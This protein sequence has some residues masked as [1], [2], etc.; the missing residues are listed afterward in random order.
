MYLSPNQ[1]RN[2]PRYL[3]TTACVPH[4]PHTPSTGR[5]DSYDLSSTAMGADPTDLLSRVRLFQNPFQRPLNVLKDVPPRTSLSSAL[6]PVWDD[7]E[8]KREQQVRHSSDPAGLI[9][10][11][12]P[13]NTPQLQLHLPPKSAPDAP[14]TASKKSSFA[15]HVIDMKTIKMNPAALIIADTRE[16]VK[17]PSFD[18]MMEDIF[19]QSR[20]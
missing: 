18:T 15:K 9:R 12:T 20:H 1:V 7:R 10:A 5:K 6:R 4:A 13:F 8:G 3:A 2:L 17:D 11:R 14:T 19:M 16:A